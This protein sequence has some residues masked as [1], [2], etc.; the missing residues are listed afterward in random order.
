[1]NEQEDLP[2]YFKS[3]YHR[4]YLLLVSQHM[5]TIIEHIVV[6]KRSKLI[7]SSLHFV[8]A[9]NFGIIFKKW[10]LS[11]IFKL[12]AIKSLAVDQGALLGNFLCML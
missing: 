7:Y 2:A 6:K 5:R 3:N 9:L 10:I 1:M 4:N 11:K 8:F 12:M